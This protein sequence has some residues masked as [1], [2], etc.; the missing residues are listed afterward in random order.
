MPKNN[1]SN[2]AET[3]VYNKQIKLAVSKFT[4]NSAMEV[5]NNSYSNNEYIESFLKPID[6][7]DFSVDTN[8]IFEDTKKIVDGNRWEEFTEKCTERYSKIQ[9]MNSDDDQMF[10]DTESESSDIDMMPEESKKFDQTSLITTFAINSLRI[11]KLEKKYS[12]LLERRDPFLTWTNWQNRNLSLV[13]LSWELIEAIAQKE[14]LAFFIQNWDTTI[15]YD[16]GKICK[17]TCRGIDNAIKTILAGKNYIQKNYPFTFFISA[18][19]TSTE[20]TSQNQNGNS[21]FRD[22]M[23]DL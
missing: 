7:N 21:I 13:S 4:A 14:N 18:Q 9:D 15:K 17:D 6:F 3:T 2:N 8:L 5:D 10:N 12:T 11:F 19:R 20:E 1:H 16:V 23:L 22:R